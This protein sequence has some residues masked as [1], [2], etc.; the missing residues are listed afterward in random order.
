MRELSW[1]M[2]R[3][4]IPTAEIEL[5]DI[6]GTG[7]FGTVHQGRWL[8]RHESVAVKVPHPH[9]LRSAGYLEQLKRSVTLELQLSAHPN[10]VKLYGWA[11][12]AEGYGCKVM[13]V[14][15][16]AHGGSLEKLI[17]TGATR[18]WTP[19]KT[20]WVAHQIACGLAFLHA[21]QPPLVH[22]DLKPANILF[23]ANST[24]KIADFGV[25]RAFDRAT[26]T[27]SA[28]GTLHFAAPEQ[29]LNAKYDTAVDVWAFGCS[30][31]CIALELP[32]TP[33]ARH[34]E[35]MSLVVE[36]AQGTLRPE[37]PASHCLH[38]YVR[39]CC[40]EAVRRPTADALVEQLAGG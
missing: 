19:S 29:L 22:R 31:A 1:V 37:V 3:R 27:A 14:M 7:N 39:A 35:N 34:A 33:F 8:R 10:V 32:A 9:H 28:V 11:A 24:P 38:A 23:D 2:V 20:L 4:Q 21:Q 36:V 6:L 16:L 17:A 13:L 25:S 12:A 15:E 18:D 40:V 5:A 30:L 26:L